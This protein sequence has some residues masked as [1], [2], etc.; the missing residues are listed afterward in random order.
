MQEVHS[1][2]APPQATDAL[3]NRLQRGADL[4]KD[5]VNSHANVPLQPQHIKGVVHGVGG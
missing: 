1:L 5:L 4:A 3:K 2:L